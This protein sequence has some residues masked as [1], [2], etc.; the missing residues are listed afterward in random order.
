M[1][2]GGRSQIL[3]G[4]VSAVV[5]E[6]AAADF[7]DL[8]DFFT[9][10]V[11]AAAAESAVSVFLL[12]VDFL[13]VEESAAAVS[14]AGVVFFFFLDFAALVSFWSVVVGVCAAWAADAGRRVRLASTSRK[15]TSNAMWNRLR[16]RFILSAFLSPPA[17]QALCLAHA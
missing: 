16:V 13:V 5:E 6:S 7:L 8:E 9:V 15:A 4:D 12:L 2:L 3:A 11:S 10:E 14:S 17:I 1:S